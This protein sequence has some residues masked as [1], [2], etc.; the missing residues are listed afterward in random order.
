[1]KLL[2][3][4][5]EGF[6]PL[7][8]EYVFDPDRVTLVVDRNEAGKSSL[9][10]AIA[11]ALYGL[12]SDRR[13]HRVITPLERWRPWAGE[14]YALELELSAGGERYVVR[15]DFA[16]GTVEVRNA[17]GTDVTQAFRE[18]RDEVPVGKKLL[19]LDAAEF[20]KCALV[21]QSELDLVVPAEE[22]ARRHATLAA[23]LENAADTR[24]GDT[25]AAEAVQ[26]LQGA[27][28]RYH[29]DVLGFEGTVD[30]AITRLETKLGML[31]AE[32]HA[33]DHDLQAVAGP[34]DELTA[35]GVEEQQH[36][37]HLA[38]LEGERRAGTVAELAR[39]LKEDDGHRAERARLLEEV[40]SL[41]AYA[42]VPAGAEAELREAIAGFT[43]AE[44]NLESLVQR[45]R[46][47]QARE[48]QQ[49][50]G[51]AQALARYDTLTLAD[52][53]RCMTLA[54]ELKRTGEEDQRLRAE[55][56]GARDRVA[57]RGAEPER[58]SALATRFQSLPPEAEQLLR[59]QASLTL[60][61]QT[62]VA[63]L[64]QSRTGHSELLRDVDAARS[65][66]RLPGWFV[67]AL[68]AGTAIAGGVVTLLHGEA[69]VWEALLVVGGVLGTGG[70][71]LLATAAGHRSA[72]RE[73]ALRALTAANHRLN[74]LRQRRAENEVEVDALAHTLG[75]RDGTEL[76]RTWNEHVG[77]IDEGGPLR[78]TQDELDRLE[79][80]RRAQLD[81]VRALL[82]PC[83]GGPADP[84]HLERVGAGIRHLAAVRQRL[85][86]LDRSWTWIDEE[87]RVVEATAGGLR[88]R[89]VR[90]LQSA[91][92]AH[93]PARP[94]NEHVEE[95]AGRV[96]S[97]ARHAVLT[98]ELVPQADRLVLPAAERA[99]L[100]QQL[101]HAQQEGIPP[102]APPRNSIAIDREAKSA[103]NALELLQ[104]RRQDIRLQINDVCRRVQ[105]TRPD[106]EAQ[107]AATAHA[108]ARAQRFKRAV[109]RAVAGIQS[110]ASDTHRRWAEFLNE[111]VS[112]LLN[113]FGTRVEQL[114]FGEDL[115]FSV[116][117]WNGQQAPRGKAVMQLSAGARDQ[118]HLAVRLAISEFLSRPG[119]PLPLLFD[120][121][122][123]TSDD[124]R[125]RAG[126]RLVIEH[127]ARQ[128]Q[129]I[130]VTCHR[131]RHELL[132][133]LDP[134]LWDAGVSWVEASSAR[135]ATQG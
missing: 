111:R 68:G 88:E 78:R 38:R 56:A 39:R 14:G 69:R 37:T 18:G 97:R 107:R 54:A 117:M 89:A 116:R 16:R 52:A 35:L 103:Q 24:G 9:L 30:V 32:L 63:E 80:R 13:S 109:E 84:S 44:R 120:D 118:L 75:L 98:D 106:K 74:A 82:A 66:R 132:A 127:F 43:S 121:V 57:A 95:L 61:V 115:D 76:M 113:A 79:Q 90:I 12:D 53:D 21:R 50:E 28:R 105:E 25:N 27:L 72:A 31:D 26:V 94:W 99:V 110:A 33:L 34:L 114:R 2:R 87:R 8:G 125:A 126:L 59:A 17:E 19:G 67:L 128:H 29:C 49:L 3:L 45:R 7:R 130:V 41:K 86:E 101:A 112:E 131:A 60:G 6:G 11:A 64:E 23:R 134:A 102:D 77:L 119:Q 83:G 81:E 48:R 20:E 46:D 124:E 42:H 36:R 123:A 108:L 65:R 100:E 5:A 93:D 22:R 55:L 1:M 122:F 4:R 129:V 40:A 15:R 62:E 91:G 10:S 85:E 135:A 71:L 96:R 104:R 47:E 73:E 92:L 70:A 51:E 133:K 58:L